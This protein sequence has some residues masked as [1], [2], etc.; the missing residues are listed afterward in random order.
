[1]KIVIEKDTLVQLFTLVLYPIAGGD[2]NNVK[3]TV[4]D[5]VEAIIYTPLPTGHGRLIDADE[6]LKKAH[7]IVF[8]Y[9]DGSEYRHRCVDPCD[10][11]TTPTIIEADKGEEE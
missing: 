7:D 11:V 10:I 4:T 2:Y 8:K 9:P 6:L 1:M 3:T 5:L